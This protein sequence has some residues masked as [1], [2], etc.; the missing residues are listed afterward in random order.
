MMY[1]IDI[2]SAHAT[3][4]TWTSI[5]IKHPTEDGF[6]QDCIISSALAMDILQSC[7]EPSISCKIRDIITL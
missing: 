7:T 5:I 6:V 1:K 3:Q 4:E 2:T